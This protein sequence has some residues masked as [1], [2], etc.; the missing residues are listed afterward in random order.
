MNTVTKPGAYNISQALKN[1]IN[2]PQGAAITGILIVYN[3]NSVI[4][5]MY[6]THNITGGIY[7]RINHGGSWFNWAKVSAVKVE[8]TEIVGV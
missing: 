6:V 4:M 8:N 1:P 7:Y 2:F 5:Q 3:T